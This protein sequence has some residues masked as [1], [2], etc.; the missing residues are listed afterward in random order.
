MMLASVYGRLGKDP[1]SIDS[2]KSPMCVS[3]VAVD[4]VDRN[5]DSTTQWFGLV[6]FGKVADK[7]AKHSKGDLIAASGRVQSN[8]W[9]NKDGQ[10]QTELQ[11]IADSVISAKAAMPSGKQRQCES[12]EQ[13]GA[14]NGLPDKNNATDGAPIN[15]DIP[16]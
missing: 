8:S 16:F 2:A 7:L 5:G 6:A 14:D 10:T 15:D 9:T 1:R 3:S 4:L 12:S 13:T 11:L